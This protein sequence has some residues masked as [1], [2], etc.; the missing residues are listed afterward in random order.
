[1]SGVIEYF[2]CVGALLVA[3][4][5]VHIERVG[6]RRN[7]AWLPFRRGDKK[8]FTAGPVLLRVELQSYDGAPVRIGTSVEP[9]QGHS[10]IPLLDCESITARVID[11]PKVKL[12]RAK[13]RAENIQR[14]IRS[15][16]RR[17]DTTEGPRRECAYELQPNQPLWLVGYL[18]REL[19]ATTDGP[20]RG[21]NIGEIEPCDGAYWLSERPPD[22]W[23]SGCGTPIAVAVALFATLFAIGGHASAW[24][25]VIAIGAVTYGL[26]WL[27]LP[28]APP[29]FEAQRAHTDVRIDS[30]DTAF[31]QLENSPM[32]DGAQDEH[33]APPLESR[34]GTRD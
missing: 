20:F 3:A 34:A 18:P 15:T 1:M 17:V 25:V 28:A 23:I 19:R 24:W 26:Q 11:G 8:R 30:A 27:T 13:L 32:H 9:L 33:A 4:A 12:R 7:D 5:H 31:A 21:D 29:N 10:V 22:R 2:G 16:L 14:A 6:R